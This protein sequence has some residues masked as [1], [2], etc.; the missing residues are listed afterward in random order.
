MDN[1]TIGFVLVVVAILLVVAEI[2]IPS[3]GVL[4]I[5]AAILDLIGLSMIF[6]YGDWYLGFGVLVGEAIILPVLAILGLY[7]W[8]RTPWGRRMVIA[9]QLDDN[10]LAAFPRSEDLE[11]LKGRVGKAVSVLRPAGVVEFDGRRVD[12]LSEGVL[13]EPNTWV[14][15]VDVRGATVIVRPIDQPPDLANITLES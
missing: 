14:R 9:G 4:M 5:I 10:K 6:V 11:K 7:I 13:I 1:V 8:P 12:C 15:C 2:V 3:G